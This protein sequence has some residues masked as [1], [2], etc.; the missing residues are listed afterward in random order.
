MCVGVWGARVTVRC[1]ILYSCGECESFEC[2]KC[3]FRGVLR[4]CAVGVGVCVCAVIV[5]SMGIVWMC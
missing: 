3:G 5:V 2:V 1:V 4:V